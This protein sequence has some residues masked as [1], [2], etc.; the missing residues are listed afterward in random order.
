[1]KIKNGQAGIKINRQVQQ[2]SVA[3][4]T[5]TTQPKAQPAAQSKAGS[6]KA[7]PVIALDDSEF[8]KY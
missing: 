8:G 6:T 3:N 1:F 2:K 4:G 7:K 5:Y